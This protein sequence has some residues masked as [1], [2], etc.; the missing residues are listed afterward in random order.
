MKRKPLKIIGIVVLVII[1]ILIAIPLFLEGKIGDIIKSNVNKNVNATFD[2]EDADLSLL[3]SFPNAEVSLN[4][5][6]LINKAPFEG[7]TL[8]AANEVSLKMGLGELFK[9]KGEPVGIRSLVVDGAQLNIT[10][11]EAENASYDVALESGEETAAEANTAE[12]STSQGDTPQAE[13][14]EG[15]QLDLQSYEISDSRIVYHDR[16]AGMRFEVSELQHEG[17]GDL[18]L[19][20]SELQTMTDGLVSFE[21]DSTNYLDRTKVKLDALIGVDLN[22]N[23]YSF[24]KNEALV[25]QLPLVF[26]GFVKM[27]D[28]ETQEVDISFKTPSSDFKNFLAV[29]PEAYSKNIEDVKTTGDFVVAGNFNGI[30]DET[31][32]PKFNISINSDNASFKYPDLPKSVDNINIDTKINNTTGITEDTYVN[33]DKLSF[34]ID[35]DRFNMTAQIKEL[36]GNTKVNAHI[37]GTMNLANISKA[38]PV[39]ADLDLKGLL[40]ADITTAFDMASI[41]KEQYGNTD[42]KGQLSLKDFEYNSDD[43]ANPIKLST[44]AVTFDP[45]RVSLD[46]L[47]GTTGQTDFQARGTIENLLGYMFNDENVKGNFDLSSNT[48]ALNDFMV[49]ETET[50][51]GEK[52]D[53]PGPD[54]QKS[55]ETSNDGDK[56]ETSGGGDAEKTSSGGDVIKIPA[57]LDVT[58]NASA[59]KVLYDNLTLTDVKGTLR[60]KDETATLSNL[61]SSIF[62]GKMALNGTV[63]TKPETPTFDMKLD[64]SRLKITETFKSLELFK[65]L[66]PIAQVLQ[67]TFNSDMSLS[68]T[69]TDALQPKLPSLSGTLAAEVSTE[70]IDESNAPLLSAL[71]SKLDFFDLKQLNLKDLK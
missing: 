53:G 9:G 46:R 44:T 26:E 6:T 36:L 22:E 17:S 5:V 19:D 64:M 71:D 24:L 54:G 14:S 52:Q 42:I 33:I 39:P 49:E 58:I 47:E 51:S 23:K 69:L 50:P 1:A 55:E 70:Q 61:T 3:A 60:I 11:D 29:I 43:F 10:I 32:I 67:G 13:P 56:K 2:F 27:N 40:A 65:A 16:A 48:F 18:S 45:N 21:M 62:D 57:F 68:G 63:S 8:F 38:Y 20:T 28:D 34:M 30:V 25:N 66:A 37:D 35:Q 12:G 4:A 31:H 7:D 41:E 15:F 59:N